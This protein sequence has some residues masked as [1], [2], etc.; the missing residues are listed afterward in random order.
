[1][2]NNGIIRDGLRI[3]DVSVFVGGVKHRNRKPGVI[4]ALCNS[5]KSIRQYE[6]MYVEQDVPLQQR[7]RD[8]NLKTL[9]RLL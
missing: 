2:C 4:V 6:Q 3:N 7:I 5:E 1:M 9:C 8:S